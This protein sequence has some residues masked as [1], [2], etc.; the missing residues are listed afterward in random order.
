MNSNIQLSL[1]RSQNMLE[2]NGSDVFRIRLK[3]TAIVE[4]MDDNVD[5]VSIAKP[6]TRNI[7]PYRS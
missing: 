6:V 2:F 3:N 4:T 5:Q 1:E 7:E